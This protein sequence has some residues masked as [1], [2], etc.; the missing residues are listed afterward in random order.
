MRLEEN[1]VARDQQGIVS[2]AHKIKS[3]AGAIGL[4]RL[5]TLA[6]QAQSPE[7]PAWWDNIADWIAALR[8]NYPRD[9]ARLKIWL[10]E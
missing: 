4:K 7:L 3:A 5:H 2:E 6:K 10:E 1:L 9:I 8:D